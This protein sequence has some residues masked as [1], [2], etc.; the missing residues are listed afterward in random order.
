MKKF[1]FRLQKVLDVN[2]IREEKAQ[3]HFSEAERARGLQS[4]LLNAAESA[5]SSQRIVFKSSLSKGINAG[6]ALI[7][8]RFG[9]R[10]QKQVGEEIRKLQHATEVVSDRRKALTEAARRKKMLE[11]LKDKELEEYKIESS[12][13]ESNEQDEIAGRRFAGNVNMKEIDAR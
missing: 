13:F 10:L 12:L 1:N 11:I 2:E 4:D 6:D 7:N 8:H 9:I 5:V 3:R